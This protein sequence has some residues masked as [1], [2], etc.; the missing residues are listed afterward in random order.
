MTLVF[1]RRNKAAANAQ[2]PAITHPE[3][4]LQ[5]HAGGAAKNKSVPFFAFSALEMGIFFVARNQ[6]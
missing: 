4:A 2:S 6:P 1:S 3:A 5:A